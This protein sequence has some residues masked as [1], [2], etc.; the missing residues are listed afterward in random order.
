MRALIVEDEPI[1][2]MDLAHRLRKFGFSQVEETAYAAES[3]EMA[4]SEAFDI[5]FMDIRL[6]DELSGLDAARSIAEDL[7]YPIVV[8]SAYKMMEEEIRR[9]VPTLRAFISKPLSDQALELALAV[10][11]R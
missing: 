1:F 3:I 11:V 4:R 8:M 9:S 5:I 7:P 2:R 6:K 10:G